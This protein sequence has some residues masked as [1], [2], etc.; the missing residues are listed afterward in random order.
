MKRIIQF[1]LIELLVVIAIIAILASMLLP[2][3]AKARMKARDISCTNN[4]KQMGLAIALYADDFDDYIVPA[5]IKIPNYANN[6]WEM[7]FALLSGYGGTTSGYGCQY[8][9]PYS[10]NT[11]FFCPSAPNPL[12]SWSAGNYQY[13]HYNIN[14]HLT[15]NQRSSSTSWED[16][17]RQMTCLTEPSNAMI[18]A[19]SMLTANISVNWACWHAYR[20]CGG[21]DLRT[22][23]NSYAGIGA[24]GM[25]NNK[26]NFLMMDGHVSPMTYQGFSQR[27]KDQWVAPSRDSRLH[28]GFDYRKYSDF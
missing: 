23:S 24:S 11:T 5:R 7:W 14:P 10:P 20:H 22:P 9:G 27:G 28:I 17:C 19:D 2:A 3:L 26:S 13:T 21:M 8:P 1:T 25:G 16:K 15:G 4:E 18:V 12:G 6:H